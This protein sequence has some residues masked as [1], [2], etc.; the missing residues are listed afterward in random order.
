MP[1]L[2][3]NFLNLLHDNFRNYNFFI[4]TGTYLGETIF[5]MEPFF[6]NLITIELSEKYHTLTKSKY[7]GKKISF[8][9]GDSSNIFQ[10]ILPSMDDTCIFFLDG[11]WSSGD[12]AKGVKDCPLV[13][14]ITHINNLYKNKGIII[15]DDVRLFGLHPGNGHNEDWGNITKETLLDILKDRLSEVYYLDSECAK[16]DRMII[17]IKSH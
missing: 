7:H 3:L 13:E 11:H 1:S 16:N 15:I 9:L 5:G 6:E 4:E 8:M 2:N 14:E 10:T 17:H 12:T